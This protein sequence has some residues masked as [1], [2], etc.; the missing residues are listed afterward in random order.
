MVSGSL[1][2]LLAAEAMA[3]T[4]EAYRP[5]VC[6]WFPACSMPGTSW[7]CGC[8]AKVGARSDQ[9]AEEQQQ[10]AL[11]GGLARGLAQVRAAQ[12]QNSVPGAPQGTASS[13]PA[14]VQIPHLAV[15]AHCLKNYNHICHS[16]CFCSAHRYP[17]S[18]YLFSKCINT[19]FRTIG[20]P[21][22]YYHMATSHHFASNRSGR[23]YSFTPACVCILHNIPI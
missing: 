15:I 19:R 14:P 10:R 18:V 22:F 4:R 17:S 23:L 11:V 12:Q 2:E 9:Q 13:S 21:I 8:V 5:T 20:L 7:R 6:C 16:C 3:L 1:T